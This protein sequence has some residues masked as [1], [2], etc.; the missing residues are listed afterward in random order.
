MEDPE[1][2]HSSH[3]TNGEPVSVRPD[4]GVLFATEDHLLHAELSMAVWPRRLSTH[5]IRVLSQY[6]QLGVFP[7]CPERLALPGAGA[8]VPVHTH[9][10][11]LRHGYR[12]WPHLDP[13]GFS[14]LSAV[15]H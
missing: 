9:T 14:L 1:E 3:A 8:A 10:D 6:V 5:L 12:V 15:V 13:D 11:P 4:A 2:F 7:S